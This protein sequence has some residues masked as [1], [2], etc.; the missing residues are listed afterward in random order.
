MYA[1]VGTVFYYTGQGLWYTGKGVVV[2]VAA[3]T[4][5]VIDAAT[6]SSDVVSTPLVPD[7]VTTSPISDIVSIIADVP[8]TEVSYLHILI[9][10][11]TIIIVSTY[12]IFNYNTEEQIQHNK[13]D[14]DTIPVTTADN[15]TE[16]CC[17]C[18]TNKK[19]ICYDNYKHVAICSDCAKQV[20]DKKCPL[21]RK[22]SRK[23]THAV[24]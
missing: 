7:I 6:S 8:V 19:T 20:V 15:I 4:S 23:F 16:Q 5:G 14:L 18:R 24:I 3:L 12:L 21:C 11:V 10:F 22:V 17:V 1:V 13:L 2:G 9:T